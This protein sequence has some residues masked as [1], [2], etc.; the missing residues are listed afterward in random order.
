MEKE[1]DRS[2]AVGE[3]SVTPPTKRRWS[4]MDTVIAL[5]VFVALVG[6]LYRVV[7]AYA[8]AKDIEQNEAVTYRIFFEADGVALPVLDELQ[9]GDMMYLHDGGTPLGSIEGSATEERALTVLDPVVEGVEV[10]SVAGVLYCTNGTLTDGSLLVSNSDQYLTKGS[11]VTLRTDRV[12]M[13]V[14]ITEIQELLAQGV[15]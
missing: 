2:P 1:K 8:D 10:V 3:G 4:T 13:T 6:L 5:L 7:V 14:R 15:H 11:V 9:S 12:I